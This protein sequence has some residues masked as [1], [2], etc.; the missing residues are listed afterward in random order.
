MVAS[1][2][3]LADEF[4]EMMPRVAAN[5]VVSMK[6]DGLHVNRPTPAQEEMWRTE[7]ARV[8]P[9]LL[10]PVFDRNIYNQI[11]EILSRARSAQ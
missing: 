4:E 3:R 11:N 10:G 8:L 7:L 9:A 2:R 5:A 1:A 6:R